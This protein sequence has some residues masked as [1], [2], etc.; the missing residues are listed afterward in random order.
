MMVRA[1]SPEQ[2]VR[3]SQD[4]CCDFSMLYGAAAPCNSRTGKR[5]HGIA[6]GKEVKAV[7]SPPEAL[8]VNHREINNQKEIFPLPIPARQCQDTW[9][10]HPATQLLLC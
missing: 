8:R 9:G 10:R 7:Q 2:E 4:I 3:M 6:Q 5:N 1:R